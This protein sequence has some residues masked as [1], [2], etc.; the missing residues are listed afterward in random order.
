MN[1]MS[2]IA[3]KFYTGW[4]AVSSFLSYFPPLCADRCPLYMSPSD[5]QSS[6]LW[7]HRLGLGRRKVTLAL[8]LFCLLSCFCPVCC[9]FLSCFL[10]CSFLVSCFV[11]RL[12]QVPILFCF[13]LYLVLTT[14]AIL[15]D[16]RY[17][18]HSSFT[19]K[20]YFLC[21]A[22]PL[23]FIYFFGLNDAETSNFLC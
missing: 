16:I 8:S 5:L 11:L 20:F 22:F 15:Y 21:L 6:G 18:H 7:Q 4:G 19:I 3:H 10:S 23:N 2:N 14:K 13:F 1:V 9:L 12:F 17:T